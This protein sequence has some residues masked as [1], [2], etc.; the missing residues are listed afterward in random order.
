MSE[1]QSVTVQS[2]FGCLGCLTTIL[3]LGAL[4]FGLPTPWGTL[5]IDI[6]PPA[7][8]LDRPAP[9]VQP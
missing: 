4:W 2:P 7:I 9:E 6:F 8:E 1:R 3:L 5:D